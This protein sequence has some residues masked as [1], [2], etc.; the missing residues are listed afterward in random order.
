[1]LWKRLSDHG[2]NWRHVYKS[3]MLL[4]YL[5]KTGSER[6][7][8]QCK[9]NIYAITTLKDFQFID[10]YDNKLK[11]ADSPFSQLTSDHALLQ[12]INA[13]LS[14]SVGSSVVHCYMLL[15]T[16]M[17]RDGKDQGTNVRERAKQLVSLLQDEDRLKAE[18][19]K[20]LKNKER[21]SKSTTGIGSHSGSHIGYSSGISSFFTS[22][23][24]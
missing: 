5:V 14:V 20:S 15:S 24:P 8:A 17:F 9:E 11:I 1:M 4:D 21:F 7:A 18:R 23:T 16:L 13:P 3:L 19:E 22:Q 2:K 12:I 10:R 6:V